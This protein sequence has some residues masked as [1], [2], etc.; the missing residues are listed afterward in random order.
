MNDGAWISVVVPILMLLAIVAV[1]IV[2]Q[3][4]HR[5][6][7]GKRCF[8]QCGRSGWSYMLYGKRRCRR[9]NWV[10]SHYQKGKEHA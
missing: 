2:I 6:R 9:C 5:W 4:E 3:F 7:R 10:Q 8:P 1:A